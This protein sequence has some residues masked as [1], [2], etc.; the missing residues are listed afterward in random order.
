V[1]LARSRSPLSFIAPI[2]ALYLAALVEDHP[3]GKRPSSPRFWVISGVLGRSQ[4]PDL[5]AELDEQ[6]AA[7]AWAAV[8]ASARAFYAGKSGDPSVSKPLLAGDRALSA[9]AKLIVGTSF[10]L[11]ATVFLPVVPRFRKFRGPY[12]GAG[13]ILSIIY[14]VSL[15]AWAMP[16]G[17]K[18]KNSASIWNI[19]PLLLGRRFSGW[20]VSFASRLHADH[21]WRA[22]IIASLR[23][24]PGN[25]AP[26]PERSRTIIETN[27]GLTA[28]GAAGIATQGALGSGCSRRGLS[29]TP[30]GR[31]IC[32]KPSAALGF[33]QLDTIQNVSPRPPSIIFWR[34]AT[35]K[36]REPM[37]GPLPWSG[38]GG[39]RASF[40][41]DASIPAMKFYPMWPAPV[42][43]G[44]ERTGRAAIPLFQKAGGR[45]N[46]KGRA[47]P[48]P[49]FAQEGPLFDP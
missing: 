1:P 19:A 47:Y 44:L 48:L 21:Q 33:V 7:R 31:S 3:P 39:F 40:T 12:I 43:G 17:R 23:L 34:A 26:G 45:K 4:R 29:D 22:P 2:I 15:P 35:R 41:H 11:L 25:A 32:R 13:A 24:H 42:S 9:F 49:D 5:G 36:Y 38:P 6:G 46:R 18:R 37:D 30:T 16:L 28:Y 10:L 14:A 27:C 20:L 8:P